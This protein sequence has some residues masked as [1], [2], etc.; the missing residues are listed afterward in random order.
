MGLQ[1]ITHLRMAA[2]NPSEFHDDVSAMT[3]RLCEVMVLGAQHQRHR[4][5]C[6]TL[7]N[8]DRGYFPRMGLLDRAFNPQPGF[9]VVKTLHGLL[10]KLGTFST[11]LEETSLPDRKSTRFQFSRGEFELFARGG[12]TRSI[13]EENSSS[14]DSYWVDWEKSQLRSALPMDSTYPLARIKFYEPA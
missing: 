1:T 7:S 4:I 6:D 11:R 3:H 12:D 5:Y 8:N 10:E 2:D 9:Y 14:A 13:D